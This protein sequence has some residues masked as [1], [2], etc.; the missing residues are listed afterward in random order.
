MNILD[1][2]I[3]IFIIFG[4]FSPLFIQIF[5][6]HLSLSPL[7]FSGTPI[8]V[9]IDVLNG[10]PQIFEALF[11]FLMFFLVFFKIKE[12]QFDSLQ[13]CSCCL[14]S[15]KI[16]CS[17]LI[18]FALQFLWFSSSEFLSCSFYNLYFLVVI[19]I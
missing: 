4:E 8:H 7:L 15:V 12:P 17:V 1:V 13:L 5:F 16:C 10:V 19:S 11:I 18:D 6:L 3:I 14:P 2:H 9:C